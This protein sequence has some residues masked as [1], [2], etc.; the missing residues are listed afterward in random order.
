MT[1]KQKRVLIRILISAVL[2]AI[3]HFILVSGPLQF[4]LYLIPYLIIGYDVLKKAILG[5]STVK[6]LTKIF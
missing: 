5:S 3:L 6:S 2:T 4:L 1:R